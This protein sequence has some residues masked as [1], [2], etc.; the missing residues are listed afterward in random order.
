MVRGQS[1][2]EEK[3]EPEEEVV[4]FVKVREQKESEGDELAEAGR[5]MRGMSENEKVEKVV[6]VQDS[7][8]EEEEREMRDAWCV[9]DSVEQTDIFWKLT[10]EESATKKKVCRDEN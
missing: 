6:L 5:E 4:M 2:E 7:V 8:E 3:T 10:K 9:T 1:I